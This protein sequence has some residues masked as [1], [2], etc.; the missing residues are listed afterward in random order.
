MLS[1]QDEE[2]V[3]CYMINQSMT[4]LF[5]DGPSFTGFGNKCQRSAKVVSKK[6]KGSA[7][8]SVVK[9]L[10]NSCQWYN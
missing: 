1:N 9:V 8:V 5:V 6:C 2:Q 3:G 7:K 10:T 4:A